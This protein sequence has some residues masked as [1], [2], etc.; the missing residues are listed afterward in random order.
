MGWLTMGLGRDLRGQLARLIEEGQL[1]LV[2]VQGSA[3]KYVVRSSEA[4]SLESGLAVKPVMNL[5]APLD[6][7][8]WDRDMVR[9]IFDFDYK[10]EVYVPA[11]KRKYGYYVLPLLYGD[12]LVGRIEPVWR[13]ESG[14]Q[15]KG[16]WREAADWDEAMEAALLDSLELFG[17]YLGTKGKVKLPAK[18]RGHGPIFRP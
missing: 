1:S 3:K 4:L 6:N 9:D 2:T 16:L 10:W 18:K 15:I 13:Q 17:S 7:L 11:A 5:V 8:L 12:R 14:L